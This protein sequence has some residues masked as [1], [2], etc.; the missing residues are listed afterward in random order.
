MLADAGAR[1]VIVGHSE[2]RRAYGETSDL[3][4]GKAQSALRGGLQ[5]IICVGETLAQRQSGQAL[6]VVRRQARESTPD[7]TS[8][9]GFALAYEPVWAIGG[10]HVPAPREIEDMHLALR[11]VLVEKFDALGGDVQILYGGSVMPSNVI[12][13][14][15][16]PGV[17]GLLIG[18]ASESAASFVEILRTIERARMPPSLS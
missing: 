8:G 5:P 1:L 6:N 16:V 15:D 17:G 4:A 14:F 3:V 13:V 18:R 10:D 12:D 11:E 7:V 2:R 9:A